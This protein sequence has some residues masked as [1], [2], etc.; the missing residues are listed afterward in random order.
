MG[1]KKQYKIRIITIVII[2]AII[3]SGY[4]PSIVTIENKDTQQHPK[5]AQSQVTSVVA[6]G[7][8]Q[9]P[10][11]IPTPHW[12]KL[13]ECYDESDPVDGYIIY[14]NSVTHDT[15]EIFSIENTIQFVKSVSEIKVHTYG[16]SIGNSN[17]KISIFWNGGWTAWQTVNVPRRSTPGLIPYG[18]TVNTF[19]VEGFQSDMNSLQVRYKARCTGWIWSPFGNIN[20]GSNSIGAFFSEVTYETSDVIS[21]FCRPSE[22]V[23]TQWF[24]YEQ[25]HWD[26]LNE[27]VIA[28]EP[29]ELDSITASPYDDGKVEEFEMTNNIQFVKEVSKIEIHTYGKSYGNTNPKVRLWWDGDWTSWKTVD[30]PRRSM[31]GPLSPGWAVNSWD[32]IGD[33]FAVNDLKVQYKSRCTGWFFIPGGW[34][35]PIGSNTVYTS[36]CNITY[37]VANSISPIGGHDRAFP[38]TSSS[39]LGYNIYLFSAYN[40]E[41]QFKI[42]E[43]GSEGTVEINLYVDEDPSISN[44]DP[45]WS[46]VVNIASTYESPKISLGNFYENAPHQIIIEI[47]NNGGAIYELD[48]LNL[49]NCHFLDFFE[50]DGSWFTPLYAK[51]EGEA[52][53]YGTVSINTRLKDMHNEYGDIIDD[54]PW[55]TTSLIAAIDDDV[56]LDEDP[57]FEYDKLIDYYIYRFKVEFRILDPFGEY[58]DFSSF[59]IMELQTSLDA[60]Q[61]SGYTNT[62]VEQLALLLFKLMLK[63]IPGYIDW[64]SI[65]NYLF[66]LNSADLLTEATLVYS[67]HHFF[68]EFTDGIWD[69]GGTWFGD[70]HA[71]EKPRHLTKEI[72]LWTSWE[73]NLENDY[74]DYQVKINWEVEVKEYSRIWVSG[75][76]YGYYNHEIN[77]AFTFEG[78]KYFNFAFIS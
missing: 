67:I 19:T 61:E 78:S 3:F 34:N 25:S 52:Y 29:G 46:I 39:H 18:W 2:M 17:P 43:I 1:V 9:T 42:T 64:G 26:L 55:F 8:I 73:S 24:P 60:P 66:Y 72:S 65:L 70:N 16:R 59:N 33:Q 12:N 7:D 38:Q 77:D 57:E 53:D 62:D 49:I 31:P 75:F 4:V 48:Y 41:I 21:D 30:L 74:G 37:E 28:P 76:G 11:N 5:T 44:S 6:D 69:L 32:L 36:Y 68:I 15:I 23:T 56:E 27:W 58:L 54:E 71:G 10:W 63:I 45:F 20:I 22:D 13:D 14:A 47:A 40:P 50:D 51:S 35:I